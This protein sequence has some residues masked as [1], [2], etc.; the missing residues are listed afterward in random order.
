MFPAKFE[1]HAPKTVKEAVALLAKNKKAKLLAGGH[2]LLPAMKVR[3][4][5]P[6]ALVDIGKIKGLAGIKV[7]KSGTTIGA[8]TTHATIAASKELAK[9][10]P[11][12]TEAA[13]QIGDA[14]VRNRGTIGGSLAHADP[15]AD[16]P[17]VMLALGAE[18]AA[19]G[20]KGQRTIKAGDFFKS[21]LTTA[22]KSNEVL[23]AIRIP[24]HQ[25]RTGCAY[26][27][28]PHPAS[29]YA[30]VGVCAW[31][32][33]DE[34]GN[35]AKASI[36]VTG[37]AATATRA[38]ATEKMLEGKKLDGATIAAASAK[39]ADSLDCMSDIFASAEYRAHLVQVYT[40]RALK[41]AA[42]RAKG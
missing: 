38:R 22:L 6:G 26:V 2:S 40:A 32:A 16:F 5:Q 18:F 28:Y 3:L 15:A 11:A 27:K 29:R 20:P 24:P 25:P 7:A 8:L 34:N 4:A 13:S 21:L 31:V 12:I 36:G 19:V 9:Q 1:Y 14:Q 35:C 33:L 10:C 30:V 42:A 41:A 39:A 17:A 23:T 37:A